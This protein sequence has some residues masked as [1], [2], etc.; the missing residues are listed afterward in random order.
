LSRSFVDG[1]GLFS[2]ESG[3]GGGPSG[4][5]SGGVQLGCVLESLGSQGSIFS[6]RK[7]SGGSGKSSLTSFGHDDVSVSA[8]SGI[9]SSEEGSENELFLHWIE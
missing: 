1:Q 6:G 9:D 7:S 5:V 3:H 4:H 2:G 8:V